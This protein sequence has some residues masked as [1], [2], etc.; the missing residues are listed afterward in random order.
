MHQFSI[1]TPTYNRAEYLP[2]VFNCLKEQ[3]EI[4]LEWIII[5]D[6]SNDNTREIVAQFNAPFSIVY[7]YQ[8][9]AGKPSAV[10]KGVSLA[11]SYISLLHD[12]DDT[13]LPNIL[14]VVWGYYDNSTGLFKE[15]CVSLAGLCV[16]NNDE[17]IGDIFPYDYFVSDH[18]EYRFNKNIKGD[19]CEFY[20]TSILKAYP[21]PIINNEKFIA[22]SFIWNRI[23]LDHKTLYIN[24]IFLRKI[25][26]KQGL[27]NQPI[28]ENNP[29]SSELFFNE[30]TNQKFSY[31]IRLK[32]SAKYIE[33]ARRN[34][35]N[36][37][38]IY[39]NSINKQIFALGFFF[40]LIYK[41]KL[42]LKQN[43]II[44]KLHSKL[45]KKNNKY[46]KK[47]I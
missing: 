12:S 38:H 23:A 22:E 7:E 15:N 25:F 29:H 17:I 3:G 46:W 16:Y 44:L 6:G 40:S 28:W 35:K 43:S 36:I 39:N 27:S 42:N 4:D 32:N 13:L 19:K 10:N 26:L 8:D 14:P 45:N 24:N 34:K 5:D 37:L 33:Y 31:S 9:N 18:I 1:I 30:T 47:I 20:L 11:D 21:F 2:A 41:L